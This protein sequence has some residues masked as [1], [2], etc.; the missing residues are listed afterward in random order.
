MAKPSSCAKEIG[1]FLKRQR[2]KS[3]LTQKNI[4]DAFHLSS[5]QFVSNWERGCCL[6]PMEYLPQLCKILNIDKEL[7]IKI[8]IEQT[9]IEINA[10]FKSA[11]KKISLCS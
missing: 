1:L 3:G 5:T 2:L 10:V 7:L 8:Y 6:P 9:E 4:S 11:H